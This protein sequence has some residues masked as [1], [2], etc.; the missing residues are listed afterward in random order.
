MKLFTKYRQVN[1][2]ATSIILIVSAFCYYMI[3]R[4]ILIA[5]LDED[6]ATEM[7]EVL[8]FVKKNDVLPAPVNNKTQQLFFTHLQK[9]NE[10][11]RI[12]TIPVFD[13]GENENEVFRQIEFPITIHANTYTAIVREPQAETEDLIQYIVLV[14]IIMLVVLLGLLFFINRYLLKK[15]WNPFYKTLDELKKFSLSNKTTLQLQSNQVTEFAQLNEAVKS[16]ANQVQQE[17]ISLKM[18]TENASH[19]MQTPLAVIRS[20]MD[21][22]V[23]DENLKADQLSQLNDIYQALGKLQHLMQSLLLLTRIENGQYVANE[24]IQLDELV[25]EKC[26]QFQELFQSKNISLKLN[27][28][29]KNIPFNKQLI[30]ILLNNLLSNAARHTKE[31]GMIVLYLNEE[32]F[33]ICN[34]GE[35][36]LNEKEIFNRFYKENNSPGMGLGLAIVKQICLFEHLPVSYSFHKKMHCFKISFMNSDSAQ[37]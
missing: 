16:M 1:L 8:D 22:L 3:V 7:Q 23:Q 34:S 19:E 2:I 14:T 21:N 31:N 10:T 28:H 24:N 27:V 9:N 5:Q 35:K 37:I 13:S 12:S 4:Q 18:F 36:S 6:L 26:I 29:Q 15:L 17:Y 33:S 30:D 11:V 25:K 20:K 32:E